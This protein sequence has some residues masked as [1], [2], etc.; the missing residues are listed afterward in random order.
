MVTAVIS[1]GKI[2]TGT[3]TPSPNIRR[4]SPYHMEELSV[5]IVA[6]M[7]IS[8]SAWLNLGILNNN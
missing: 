1:T 5:A 4:L 7:A 3:I 2:A 8:H 6:T